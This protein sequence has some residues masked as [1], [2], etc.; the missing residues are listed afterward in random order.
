MNDEK[1]TN[2]NL[3]TPTE[4]KD[5]AAS[6]L[7]EETTAIEDK[8]IEE[9]REKLLFYLRL[10]FY[11]CLILFIISLLVESWFSYIVAESLAR[12]EESLVRTTTSAQRKIKPPSNLK[13]YFPERITGYH[14]KGKKD[15]PEEDIPKAEA[16]YEP[17]DMNLQLRSPI[18]IYCQVVYFKDLRGAEQFLQEKLRDYPKN[19]QAIFMVNTYANTGFANDDSAY[20]LGTI[21]NGLVFWFKTSY[22]EI[23][24]H[25]PNRLD[26]LKFHNEKVASEV[27]KMVDQVDSGVEGIEGN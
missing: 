2:T 27:L 12:K 13:R 11:A 3:Q 14:L 7:K 1:I 20:F 26:I 18:V 21:Y 19:Q 5:L 9:R 16:V 25:E 22:V 23:I 24:P 17:E 8:R 15:L 10:A 4:E 6:S